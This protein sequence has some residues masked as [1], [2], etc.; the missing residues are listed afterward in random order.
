VTPRPP[1]T[2]IPATAAPGPTTA[3][4][5][6]VA[7]EDVLRRHGPAKANVV[8]VAR[9]L[10]VS[11]STVYQ[12]FSSKSALRE[13]VARRWL[14]RAHS[15]LDAIVES[16]RPAPERLRQWL[17]ALFSAKRKSALDDPELFA[18]YLVVVAEA[19][20]VVDEH[21]T[22]LADQVSRI[23][24]DGVNTGE[25]RGL[26][27]RTTAQAVLDATSRFHDP[28]NARQWSAPNIDRA[29]NAVCDLVLAGLEEP[30]AADHEA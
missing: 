23:L 30:H 18:T 5:I 24:I 7:T 28:T 10:G 8:D 19:S 12:H 13:A 27:P 11:H 2:A 1:Q 14:E 15:G 17:K 9:S 16:E 20:T 26:E 29:F 4:A 22:I 6:L 3:E 25:F 21:L